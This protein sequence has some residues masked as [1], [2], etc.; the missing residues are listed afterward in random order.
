MFGGTP[1]GKKVLLG[2]LGSAVLLGLG[3]WIERKERYQIFGRSCIGGGWRC[4]LPPYSPCI[5]CQP[6]V[7]CRSR[8]S[9]ETL[10]FLLLFAVAA[11]MI[12]HSL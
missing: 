3:V 1:G 12:G 4:F 7:C 5:T 10:D 2:L 6:R 11:A 8:P 9:G